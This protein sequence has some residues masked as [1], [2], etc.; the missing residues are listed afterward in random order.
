LIV[1]W[2]QS[3]GFDGIRTPLA[4]VIVAN[5]GDAEARDV[6]FVGRFLR[7]TG[8]HRRPPWTEPFESEVDAR[9]PIIG[10]GRR[11]TFQMPQEALDL[12][13]AKE[14]NI[15]SREVIAAGRIKYGDVA[16]AVRETGFGWHYHAESARYL[17][18]EGRDE[19]NYQD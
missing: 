15:G 2:I 10:V 12:L 3:D 16:G 17:I 18:P 11:F 19:L 4:W 14:I 8:H 7:R 1:R 6:E 5:V 9:T 13:E